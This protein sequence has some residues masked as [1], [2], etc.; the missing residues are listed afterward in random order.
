[1]AM[2]RFMMYKLMHL[3][4]SFQIKSGCFCVLTLFC[5]DTTMQNLIE[6]L[7]NIP[8]SGQDLQAMSRKLGNRG[9]RVYQYSQLIDIPD[10]AALLGPS[11]T[12]YILFDIKSESGGTVGH[13]ACVIRNSRGV[14][15]YDPYGLNLS[16]D[17]AITGEPPYL[18][19]ILA[20][21]LDVNRSR[22]QQ[23]RDK[24]QTCGRHIVVRSL[25]H[26]LTNAEYNDQIVVPV[27]KFVRNTDVFVSLMTA[28]LDDSDRAVLTFFGAKLGGV[29]FP[30]I[31]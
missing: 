22:H 21:K 6:E 27:D 8:L 7:E 16:E 12:A 30:P 25:F 3:V 23:F 2:S 13:W 18:N 14:S 4:S 28:F 24:I 15:Y 26:F 9:T 31:S 29:T 11:N 5:L 10:V 20:G 1:M 19:R 17:L